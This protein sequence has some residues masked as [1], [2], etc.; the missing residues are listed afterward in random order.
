VVDG[1]NDTQEIV[2][3][4]LGKQ[5][6]GLTLYAG[7]TIM[8]DGRVALIL[9][10]LGIGQRSGVLAEF[11]E[12]ARASGQ[13]KAQAEITQ[14]R[15]LLFRAGSFARLA[16]PLS[17][18]ARLE[19]FPHSSIEYASGVPVVQYRDGILPLVSL[20]T[21][22]EPNASDPSEPT[23][24]VQ[25]VVFN[26]G[27]SSVGMVVDEILD[28]T[29]DAVT[30]RQGSDR[31]GLLGSAVVG[32]QVTD[33]LDLNAVIRATGK[34]WFEGRNGHGGGQKI[35]LADASAFSRAMVRSGL[36]MAG[37]VVLEAANLE[38]AITVLEQQGADVVLASLDLPPGGG[39]DLLAAMRLR[40]EWDKIPVVVLAG[41][42]EQVRVAAARE[43]GFE[44]C[45]PKFDRLLVLESVARLVSPQPACFAAAP[46]LGEATR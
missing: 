18:V 33:F 27:N 6:K 12:Q 5:L 22:L 19:E 37:Y 38:Q 20:R 24:P 26:D 9:D 29:E 23:D 41:S 3:K 42:G 40:K 8:G 1:I 30:V 15:L 14:Q 7:A 39:S 11:T 25:V 34:S 4:P 35:L 44:D 16:V 32:K 21:V 10:V 43:A 13:Q 36:D 28:V 31:N 17:L 46:I 45:Q 2:V